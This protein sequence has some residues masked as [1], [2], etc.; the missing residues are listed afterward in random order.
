MTTD[1]KGRITHNVTAGLAV[2]AFAVAVVVC[3]SFSPSSFPMHTFFVNLEGKQVCVVLCCVFYWVITHYISTKRRG[4][5][6]VLGTGIVCVLLWLSL[7][8]TKREPLDGFLL[9]PFFF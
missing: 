7:R 5:R 9:L 3:D 6:N 8:L 2:V 4:K 1:L